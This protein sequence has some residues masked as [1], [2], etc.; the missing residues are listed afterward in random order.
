M[1]DPTEVI[2]RSLREYFGALSEQAL[3]D[4]SIETPYGRQP[5]RSRRG[6]S[7]LLI[8][9]AV[10]VVMLAVAALANRS[11]DHGSL[12]TGSTTTSTGSSTTVL[13]GK[14]ERLTKPLTLG[15]DIEL[16]PPHTDDVAQIT[17]TEAADKPSGAPIPEDA[18]PRVILA[19]ATVTDYGKQTSTGIDLFVDDRLVWVIWYHDVTLPLGPGGPCCSRP[20]TTTSPT[21]DI[22][23]IV[24]A[25][26]GET[27]G[28]HVF[29]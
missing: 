28:S 11:D 4:V 29:G 20:S 6:R 2:E 25:V 3:Q 1:S 13:D 18:I 27:F 21:G 19:R 16:V 17:G 12:Q 7:A 8:C 24:D 10:V 23:N 15:S 5:R 26:S 22:V 9:A 14:P